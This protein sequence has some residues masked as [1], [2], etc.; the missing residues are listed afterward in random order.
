MVVG[1]N[2][3]RKRPADSRV[4]PAFEPAGIEQQAEQNGIFRPEPAECGKTGKGN[5][6]DHE[7]AERQKQAKPDKQATQKKLSVTPAQSE[8]LV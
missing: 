3:E 2:H 8:V 6:T 5:S 1:I 7:T 4:I